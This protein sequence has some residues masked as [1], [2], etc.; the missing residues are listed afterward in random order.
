MLGN[1]NANLKIYGASQLKKI[2]HR[3]DMLA[4][5][6]F[7]SGNYSKQASICLLVPCRV[8]SLYTFY[9]MW[10]SVTLIIHWLCQNRMAELAVRELVLLAT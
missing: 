5:S 6:E 10:S 4:P 7:Q 9:V 1:I 8:G 2:S 3:L